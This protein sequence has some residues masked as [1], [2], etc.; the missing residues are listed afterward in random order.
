[1]VF[2]ICWWSLHRSSISLQFAKW[3]YSNS[4]IISAFNSIFLYRI[5]PHQLFG[6]HVRLLCREDGIND[7][8][9]PSPTSYWIPE[10]VGCRPSFCL[11][12]FDSQ[13]VLYLSSGN[14]LWPFDKTFGS[15]P[16]FWCSRFTLC[17]FYSR[18]ESTHCAKKLSV[19]LL[20]ET[21]YLETSIW[22]VVVL[23]GIVFYLQRKNYATRYI[24][25]SLDS[26]C[27]AV[28]HHPSL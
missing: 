8:L 13:I 16:C 23:T 21:S 2:S 27:I 19:F 6:Y 24:R 4:T 1:M 14:L 20:V 9:A 28:L 18:P 25:R 17:I 11:F 12:V 5:F 22:A 26:V 10:W 7:C 3:L 15:L